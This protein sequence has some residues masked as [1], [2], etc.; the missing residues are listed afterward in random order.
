MQDS[1]GSPPG[2][3]PGLGVN[4]LTS[5][6]QSS[7]QTLIR[8]LTLEND[9]TSLC[10]NL[11]INHLQSVPSLSRILMTFKTLTHMGFLW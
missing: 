8:S 1:P 4:L 7:E 10:R 11:F 3:E 6:F 2:L 9:P 5:V